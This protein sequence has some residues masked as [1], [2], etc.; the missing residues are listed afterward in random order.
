MNALCGV[1]KIKEKLPDQAMTDG[2][3]LFNAEGNDNAQKMKTLLP[4]CIARLI[5]Y[6]AYRSISG[7]TQETQDVHM[8][9]ISVRV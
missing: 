5:A 2:C 1:I 3:W 6:L 9:S 4:S 7:L 8:K